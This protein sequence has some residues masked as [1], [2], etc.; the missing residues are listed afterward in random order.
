MAQ[1]LE[2]IVQEIVVPDIH[3][4]WQ[5]YSRLKRIIDKDTARVFLLGDLRPDEAMYQKKLQGFIKE[6]T[7]DIP[8]SFWKRYEALVQGLNQIVAKYGEDYWIA[9]QEGKLSSAE[10]KI[11]GEFAETQGQ[12]GKVDNAVFAKESALD[13]DIHE[14][15]IKEVKE[16]FKEVKW[17]GTPGNHDTSFIRSQVRSVDWLPYEQPLADE[18]II[19]GL[20]CTPKVGECNEQFNGPGLKYAP[21]GQEWDDDYDKLED[22]RIW[23]EWK[24]EA[25]D[26][27]VV[28]CGGNWGKSRKYKGGLGIT[29]LGKKNGFVCYS[30]HDHNGI[31]YRDPESKVLI[32]RP[33]I[34]HIAKVYRAGKMVK[35]IELY[36]VPQTVEAGRTAAL[37]QNVDD[38]VVV[39]EKTYAL[40]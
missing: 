14:K 2:K 39:P 38:R 1:T 4:N 28:H 17:F 10:Q 20:I 36:R 12:L 16:L 8:D 31:V 25:I 7:K 40:D 35:K 30:G 13:Y 18:K 3:N 23:N 24:D 5:F 27:A 22:S 9:V 29:A 19:G 33:G 15:K 21:L 26:L 32:I 6:A 34:K 11:L 37:V